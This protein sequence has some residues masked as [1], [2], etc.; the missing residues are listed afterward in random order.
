[1]V[2]IAAFVV[3]RQTSSRLP[4]KALADLHGE[5]VLARIAEKL[6]NS[7]LVSEIWFVTSTNLEDKPIVDLANSLGLKSHRGD[8]E[9]VLAR[10][11][12][13]SLETTADYI[14]EVGGDCPLVDSVLIERGVQEAL[15]SG[16]DFTSNAFK[17]PFTYPVGYDFILLKRSALQRAHQLA[18]LQSERRQP[19]QFIVKNPELFPAKHFTTPEP[20]NHWRWTLDYPE[21]LTFF[22]AIYSMLYDK[23][24][25]FNSV[26][27]ISALKARPDVV[28]LNSIHAAPVEHSTAWYTG[29]FARE[30]SSDLVECIQQAVRLEQNSDWATICRH[31]RAANEMLHE[32]TARAEH[33]AKKNKR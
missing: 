3:A 15:Q 32:L 12:S 10:L 8:P 4:G 21:D 31:Y 5:P 29:S 22:R 33:F 7:A 17:A 24:P 6:K 11:N 30:L 14:L 16:A 13:A 9:D 18:T 26:D 28:A 20:L 2:S 25:N 19:F 27:L 1:M 23:N